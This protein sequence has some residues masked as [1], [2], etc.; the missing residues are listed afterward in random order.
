[1]ELNV[2]NTCDIIRE[3]AAKVRNCIRYFL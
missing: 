2:I 1:M 3:Y